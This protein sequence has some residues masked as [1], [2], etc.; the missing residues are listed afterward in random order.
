MGKKPVANSLGNENAPNDDE[1]PSYEDVINESHNGYNG[2]PPVPNRPSSNY[3]NGTSHSNNHTSS[4]QRPPPQRPSQIHRPPSNQSPQQQKPPRP[5]QHP[6]QRPNIPWTYPKNFQCSKCHNTGYK[7]K[8][9]KS[10][11]SCWRKFAPRNNVNVASTQSGYSGSSFG[12]YTT[13][14]SNFY[15]PMMGYGGGAFNIPV[16]GSMATSNTGTPLVVRPGDPRLGGFV[17]GE[18]RGTG[19]TSF[20]LDEDICTVCNGI[21][22]IIR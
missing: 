12:Y 10:C 6:Q 5:Q 3:N 20:F 18:C 19:R 22:R 15:Q 16:N 14:M 21:G 2:V 7:L 11:R 1:L 4:Y 13:P 8:N 17:C 9:G